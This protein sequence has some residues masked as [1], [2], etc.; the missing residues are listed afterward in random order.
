MTS[1]VRDVLRHYHITPSQLVAGGWHVT[2]RFRALCNL[3]LPDACRIEDFSALYSIRR[4][5]KGARFFGV[6]T[7]CEKLIVNLTDSDH[8]WGDT[9]IRVHKA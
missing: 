2:L 5:K 6:K 4:T 9:S 3:Y 8:V 1:F 7:D